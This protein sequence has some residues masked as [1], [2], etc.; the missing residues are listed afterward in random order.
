MGE[1]QYKSHESVL[2]KSVREGV[3]DDIRTRLCTYKNYLRGPVNQG[4]DR[5]GKPV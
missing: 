4:E 5:I 2:L 1:H 3:D